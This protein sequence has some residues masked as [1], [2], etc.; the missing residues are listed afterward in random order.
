MIHILIPIY[1]NYL[2]YYIIS[3]ANI[4][5]L[6]TIK[7]HY[8]IQ[9]FEFKKK[10]VLAANSAGA[11]FTSPKSEKCWLISDTVIHG[12]LNEAPLKRQ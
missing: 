1:T 11:F 9:K 2:Q 3:N 12:V 6:S 8:N 10:I 7:N 5:Q 4:N